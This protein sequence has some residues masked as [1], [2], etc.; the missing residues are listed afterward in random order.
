MWLGDG[1][2]HH[3]AYNSTTSLASLDAPTTSLRGMSRLDICGVDA[4]VGQY[5]TILN[6]FVDW[7]V[8]AHL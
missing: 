4:L 7:S 5:F 1:K 3:L 8:H 6:T 2:P